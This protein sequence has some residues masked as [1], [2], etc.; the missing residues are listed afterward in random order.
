MG[1]GSGRFVGNSMIRSILENKNR[2]CGVVDGLE[3]TRP[4]SPVTHTQKIMVKR[5][6]GQEKLKKK[7][8]LNPRRLV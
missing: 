3:K 4:C 7:T 2:S 8:S 6:W 1:S 5:G